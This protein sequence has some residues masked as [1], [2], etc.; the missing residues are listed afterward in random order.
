MTPPLGAWAP[1]TPQEVAR[2]LEGVAADWYVIGGWA[3]DLWLGCATRPHRDIEIAVPSAQ[4]A[5]VRARLDERFV[6]YAHGGGTQRRLA[7]ADPFPRDKNQCWVRD[8]DVWRL[9][10]MRD[11]GDETRWVFRRDARLSAP[12]TQIVRRT[13]DGIAYLAPQAVLLFKA[14]GRRAKDESDFDRCLPLLDGEARAWLAAALAQTETDHP[15]RAR[16]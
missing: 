16:L 5:T 4:F 6:L 1:W 8:G 14:R 13:M 11:P 7:P 2:Q 3:I 9:D 15:W 12:R 10:V